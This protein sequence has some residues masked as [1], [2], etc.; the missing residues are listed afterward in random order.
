VLALLCAVLCCSLVAGGAELGPPAAAKYTKKQKRI[1]RAKLMKQLKKNPRLIRKRW[2]VRRASHLGFSLPLTAR[3][4][5]AIRT[6]ATAPIS[7]ADANDTV[8]IDLGTGATADPPGVYAGN[9][10]TSV[11]GKFKMLGQFG[12]DTIGYGSLGVMELDVGDVAL[13]GGGF[14]LVNASPACGDGSPLLK[15]GPVS[16]T[17]APIV[18]S[19]DSRGGYLNWLTGDFYLRLW[20]QWS[21]NSLRQDVLCPGAFFWTNRIE[22]TTVIP[23]DMVGQ[24]SVSP[25]FTT[26]SKLRLFKVAIADSALA[27]PSLFAQIHYCREV[28]AAPETDPAPT[29]ACAAADGVTADARVKVDTLTFEVLIGDY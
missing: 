15:T 28:T 25:A 7:F 16:I 9:V 8:A 10:T 14:P 11:A 4:T 17:E 18:A 22:G 6:T 21:M 1:L 29:V 24:F 13:T 26:D 5:P 2:F 27:Q 23:I 19:G 12:G 3:L 20:T